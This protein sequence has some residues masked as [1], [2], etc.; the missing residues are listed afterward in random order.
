M[1]TNKRSLAALCF[2]F[3]LLF[4]SVACAQLDKMR[5]VV[6]IFKDKS[7]EESE[8]ESPA[9]VQKFAGQGTHNELSVLGDISTS[10]EVPYAVTATINDK[11]TLL[12]E[13]TGPC[14]SNYS[15]CSLS[16]DERCSIN[17]KGTL[18]DKK[19]ASLSSCNTDLEVIEDRL[20]V[21][22]K[23]MSGTIVCSLGSGDTTGLT[24][25][26]SLVP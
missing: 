3:G 12:I 25:D 16:S 1:G 14:I 20:T 26:I 5:T 4:F 7:T 18:S 11:G 10:C 13:G 19:I 24:F 23:S 22:D 17:A 9:G 6:P 15:N 8:E 21:S 2:L